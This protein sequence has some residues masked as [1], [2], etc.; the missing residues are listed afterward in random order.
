L[1]LAGEALPPW[2]CRDDF[3]VALLRAGLLLAASIALP[4]SWPSA[5]LA[6]ESNESADL[7]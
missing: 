4:K 2:L 1:P 6:L 7:N 3:A 5:L